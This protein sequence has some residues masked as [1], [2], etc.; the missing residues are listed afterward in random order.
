M[1]KEL[2]AE[3]AVAF[4]LWYLQGKS[5]QKNPSSFNGVFLLEGSFGSLFSL[6]VRRLADASFAILSVVRR[7]LDCE[8]SRTR[9]R[10][11]HIMMELS[12]K[13]AIVWIEV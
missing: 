6:R 11:N 12:W 8:A 1:E 9:F 13:A 2:E 3:E 10:E 5:C 4:G 7:Q